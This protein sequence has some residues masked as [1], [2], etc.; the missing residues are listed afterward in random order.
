[1]T[2]KAKRILV[3]LDGAE[4]PLAVL[5]GSAG[6]FTLDTTGIP[7]GAHRLRFVTMT[8]D[9]VTGEREVAFTVRNGP[10][11]AL[12]GLE[13]DDEV[14]G[15]LALKVGATDA[16]VGAR[17][18]I[19]SLE[20]HRGLPF[21]MGGFA[22]AVVILLA[23]ILATEPLRFNAYQTQAAAVRS[24]TV[25][26]APPKP[27]DPLPPNP[28]R[29]AL[30]PGSFL[31][32]LDFDPAKADAT[33]GAALYVQDCAGCH[34]DRGQ[35]HAGQSATLGQQGIYPRLAGQPAAYAYRQLYSFAKGWRQNDVM[36]AMASALAPPDWGDVAVY[37]EGLKGTPAPPAPPISRDMRELAHA[38]LTLGRPERGISRCDGCHGP[39]GSGVAPY[40]P[41]LGGQDAQY[42]AAQMADFRDGRRRNSMLRLMEPV[43]HGLTPREI[44][45]LSLY[46]QG[47]G[48]GSAD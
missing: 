21:W 31:P 45:A 13:D 26:P 34:G 15:R 39:D 33:R 37:L 7:D 4:K 23:F 48:S 30:A 14:R 38:I 3:Y 20:L 42:F 11:I 44:E 25:P 10:G 32:V 9:R 43:A 40:F 16:A 46:F 17:L 35:G 8:G 5:E 47:Q 12:A 6:D 1:M 22:L 2:E 27:A 29:I 19:P 18:D 41:A 36:Q 24:A 28:M